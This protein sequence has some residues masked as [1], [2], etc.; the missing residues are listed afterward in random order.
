[1]YI[2]TWIVDMHMD[3]P[4]SGLVRYTLLYLQ[5]ISGS[6]PRESLFDFVTVFSYLYKVLCRYQELH[7]QGRY[8]CT[9]ATCSRYFYTP[10]TFPVGQGC[11][12]VPK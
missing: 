1:M 10:A 3:G 5:D 9:V 6:L 11:Q 12:E 8:L 4:W 2:T 7:E